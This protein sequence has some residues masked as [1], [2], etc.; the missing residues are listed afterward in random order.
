MS[1]QSEIGKSRSF[2]AVGRP[3]S[4][5]SAS[6]GSCR[7]VY[8]AGMAGKSPA[9]IIH[10]LRGSEATAV[11]V[12]AASAMEVATRFRIGKLPDAALLAH[13]FEAII[14]AQGFVE[15]PISVHHARLAGDM[16]IAHKNPFDRFLIAQALAEGLL[17]VSHE[18]LFKGSGSRSRGWPPLPRTRLFPSFETRWQALARAYGAIRMSERLNTRLKIGCGLTTN[19]CASTDT[20]LCFEPDLQKGSGAKPRGLKLHCSISF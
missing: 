18:T 17:L 6:A 10:V 5:T 19:P 12:S 1:S 14:A 8:V 3:I 9:F 20:G 4:T 11:A 2:H 13:D 16:N 7:S 15:L